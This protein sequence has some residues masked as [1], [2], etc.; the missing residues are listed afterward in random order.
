MNNLKSLQD[1]IFASKYAR[2][3]NGKK[4]TWEQAVDRVMDMHK[5]T[6]AENPKV[7]H[8]LMALYFPEIE[9][10]Y[11]DQLILGA[12]RALQWGGPQLIKHNFRM[13][14]CA[15]SYANRVDFFSELMYILLC[16]A[17]VGYSVQ[18]HHIAMLPVVQGANGSGLTFMVQD[19]IEGWSDA[20]KSLVYAYFYNNPVPVFN[21]ELV[22][23]KGSPIS[24]G[25]KAPGPEPL[26]LMLS[27]IEG[28]LKS[29]SYR[30]LAPLEVHE[31]SCII[32]DAVISGGVRR[33]ALL[34]LF[35][36]DDQDMVTCKTG[37]WW[38]KKPHLARSNN[39]A[40]ILPDTPK[41]VYSNIFTSTKQFGEPSV[42]FL[43]DS[44]QLLNPCAEISMYP[45]W[46]NEDGSKQYG[47]SVCNLVEINGRK[48]TSL[49]AFIKAGKA[50][51][52]LATIQATYTNFPYLGTVTEN[53]IRRDA[54]IGV[55]ITG[56]AENPEILF[57]PDFQ[58][59]VAEEIKGV[60]RGIA[61]ALD[62]NPAARTTTIK[63][64]GTSS[65]LLGT[66]SGIHAFDSHRFIR[67]VQANKQEQAYQTLSLVNPEMVEPSFE[68][69]SDGV[70]SFPV[71]KLGDVLIKKNQGAIEFLELVKLTQNNWVEAGTNWD[72][73]SYAISPQMTH[74][75]SNTVNVRDYEWDIVE[76]YLWEN[77]E[78]FCGVS[79]MAA[80]GS[81]A[82]AQAPFTEVLDEVELAKEYGAA[83]ILA[84]GL[85]VDGIHAFGNLWKAIDTALGIG[86][87][88]E[89]TVED[90]TK[91][92]AASYTKTDAGVVILYNIGGVQVSDLNAIQAH[93]EEIVRK[94][95][96]WVRRF[97]NFAKKYLNNNLERTG[98][99]LKQVSIFHKWNQL[100]QIKTINWSEIEW[101]EEIKEAGA[102]SATA[103]AGGNCEVIYSN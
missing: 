53:I 67:H 98:Q 27:K 25:F 22:R 57:N 11:K 16:G 60:N 61:F 80:K 74:N 33:S 17:G 83:S 8:D 19:S 14:N 90:L 46:V 70:I 39:A 20:V 84:G 38:I 93:L 91:A 47:F 86:E 1:Y 102:D 15:S 72:H 9:E 96:D 7:A 94:K 77:R 34:V 63:P 78:Y 23:P 65:A 54:L 101:E 99:C 73:P 4:E 13:Y 30:K 100:Q 89:V 21:F 10:A 71:E 36:A 43:T 37:D 26:K 52:A 49:T 51:A 31:I 18:K 75:V 3:V 6:L 81:L 2:T 28:I 92:I 97:K 68:K 5:K 50:A 12:Q 85:N 76:E 40:A 69:E 35:S 103:C 88:L 32:A 44:E 45:T 24:G 87:T 58:R 79:M 42:I 55:G 41:E 82:Y 64:A 62:I 95:I 59:K 29:A 48:V 66:S 56:M